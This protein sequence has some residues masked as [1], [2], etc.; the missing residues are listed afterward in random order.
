AGHSGHPGVR[1]PWNHPSSTPSMRH[2]PPEYGWGY[3]GSYNF[4]WASSNYFAAMG[5]P[6]LKGSVYSDS[7]TPSAVISEDVAEALSPG[8]DPIGDNGDLDTVISPIHCR[9]PVGIYSTH[10]VHL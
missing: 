8:R 6:I 4:R 10:Q 9:Q 2:A 5:I 7:E 3:L 1:F